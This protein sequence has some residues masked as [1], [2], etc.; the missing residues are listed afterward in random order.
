MHW[1]RSPC[2]RAAT[3]QT[4]S[5]DR[6]GLSGNGRTELGNIS[7]R[8]TMRLTDEASNAHTLPAFLTELAAS[9]WAS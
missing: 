7:E 9:I 3:P 6:H 1:A 5:R 4:A 8:R 2:S